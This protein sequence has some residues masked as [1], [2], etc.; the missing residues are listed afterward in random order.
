MTDLELPAWCVVGARVAMCT[1]GGGIARGDHVGFGTIERMTATQ[2]VV[3]PE[4]R[5]MLPR[6]FNKA[7]LQERA[8]R[9]AWGSWTMLEDAA[10]PAVARIVRDMKIRDV[11]EHIR[12]TMHDTTF[13]NYVGNDVHRTIWALRETCN[14]MLLVLENLDGDKPDEAF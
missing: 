12:K 3:K 9:S 5:N 14:D 10:T 7:T 4:S 8:Q 6:R 2:I 1:Y 13:P 11:V